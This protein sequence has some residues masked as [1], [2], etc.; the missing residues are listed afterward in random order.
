M[1]EK[2][3]SVPAVCAACAMIV[4]LAAA[5]CM[6]VPTAFA[7][8]IIDE[9]ADVKAPPPPEV[10]GVAI[11]PSTTA[12]LILDFNSQ[13]CNTER[14][15]RCV[16]T[17]PGVRNLLK[18]A[19]AK[20]VYVVYSVSPGAR[21]GDIAKE[22]APER[23]D[24]C[25]ESG[26]DKFL[27]TDLEK[28]LTAKGIKTVIVTGTASHGAVLH[29]A[30]GAALK[31]F[32]VIVPIDAISAESLYAEQYVVWHLTNA[33]RVSAQVTLTRMDLIRYPGE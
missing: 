11:E 26:P 31:G 14:R 28:I 32:K 13:T 25:V 4:L 5:L 22:L 3:G 8:T 21:P 19:R 10:K 6:M 24:P 15:P 29:T 17:I 18:T 2:A 20:G 33:P 7:R 16:A 27:N 30:S 23:G 9:W 12:L 1:K